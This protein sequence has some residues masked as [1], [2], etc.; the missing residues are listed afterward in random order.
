LRMLEA[1]HREAGKLPW[2]RLFVP[3]IELAEQGFAVS[4]RLHALLD[5][6]RFLRD[7]PAAR[8]LFYRPDGGALPVGQRL[9]NPQLAAVLLRV[10]AEGADALYRGDIARDIVA[11]VRREPSPGVLTE[12]DLAAWR[13]VRR[14]ALCGAYR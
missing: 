4:P 12:A 8:A 2:G 10:A 3:A 5:G 7:D 13:P 1:A 14:E 9:R 6:D 11:T